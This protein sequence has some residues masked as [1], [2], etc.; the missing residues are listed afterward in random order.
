VCGFF[1]FVNG[2]RMAEQ[3]EP[4]STERAFNSDQTENSEACE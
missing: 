4:R 2:I 1:L 3:D